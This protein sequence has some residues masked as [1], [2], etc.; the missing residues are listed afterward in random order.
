MLNGDKLMTLE[1]VMALNRLAIH[2]PNLLN[3]KWTELVINDEFEPEIEED[4]KDE[5][6]GFDDDEDED[7]WYWENIDRKVDEM[8]LAKLEVY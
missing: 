4:P 8:R 2:H 3:P 5:W 6:D 7:Y 1:D